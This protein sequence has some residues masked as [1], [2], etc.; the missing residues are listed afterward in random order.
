M[1]T[2]ENDEKT[3]ATLIY[4]KI[5]A[6]VVNAHIMLLVTRNIVPPFDTSGLGLN[7]TAG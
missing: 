1:E 6:S 5:A 3:V 2:K 7:T 4:K